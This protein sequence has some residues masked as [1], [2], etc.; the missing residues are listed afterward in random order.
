MKRWSIIAVRSPNVGSSS[1]EPS[2]LP[3]MPTQQQALPTPSSSLS[4]CKGLYAFGQL[5]SPSRIPSPSE[6]CPCVQPRPRTTTSSMFQPQY[7][8]VTS[9]SPIVQRRVDGRFAGGV[10]RDVEGHQGPFVVSDFLGVLPEGGSNWCHR[11]RCARRRDR[12]AAA[13]HRA[14]AK[15]QRPPSHRPSSRMPAW[16]GAS[17]AGYWRNLRRD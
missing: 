17:R 1:T 14:T 11:L 12:S 9:V 5:S 2:T 16:S 10:G 8:Q 6:S 7:C 13:Q 3:T 15:T 4:S